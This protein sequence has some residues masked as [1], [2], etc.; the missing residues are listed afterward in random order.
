MLYILLL[1]TGAAAATA[2]SSRARA[3]ASATLPTDLHVGVHGHD[4]SLLPDLRNEAVPA[5]QATRIP[6][7]TRLAKA[8]LA[9]SARAAA[10][11]T[12]DETMSRAQRALITVSRTKRRNLHKAEKRLAAAS[13][14]GSSDAATPVAKHAARDDAAGASGS[15]PCGGSPGIDTPSPYPF[16]SS[17]EAAAAVSS[18]SSTQAAPP[19]AENEDTAHRASG[20]VIHK[21]TICQANAAH[22]ESTTPA[23]STSSTQAAPSGAENEDT[24]RRASGIVPFNDTIKTHAAHADYATVPFT[25]PLDITAFVFT[26]GSQPGAS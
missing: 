21:T 9:A 4:A 23:S 24:A 25:R 18:A 16:P 12:A 15:A 7:S 8:S 6:C 22:A 20:I 5:G 26:S 17:T 14:L 3:H 2:R 11:E 1:T 10:A 19:G 13:S